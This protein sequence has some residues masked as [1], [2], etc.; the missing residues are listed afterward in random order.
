MWSTLELH[1]TQVCPN[2]YAILCLTNKKNAFMCSTRHKYIKILKTHRVEGGEI[3]DSTRRYVIPQTVMPLRA[4]VSIWFLRNLA[5]WLQ[6][7]YSRLSFTHGYLERKKQ[8]GWDMDTWVSCGEATVSDWKM[9]KNT[10]KSCELWISST[11]V[12]TVEEIPQI[13]TYPY[14]SM[15]ND[16]S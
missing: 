6:I 9:E 10:T 3:N 15:T 8:F 1:Q 7:I 16:S 2:K 12:T 4:G 5:Q 11:V 14:S 13:L